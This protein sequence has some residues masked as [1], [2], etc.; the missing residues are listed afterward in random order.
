M[1]QK[2]IEKI[3]QES[4]KVALLA[5]FLI[6]GVLA[7]PLA[8]MLAQAWEE[9]NV[10]VAIVHLPL[11]LGL[12]LD[13][14][15]VLLI[16]A[17]VGF[18]V[19]MTLDPKKR[20]QA[21]LLWIGLV[22]AMFVFRSQGLI[23][24]HIEFVGMIG[25]W[26]GGI[27]TGIL[28]VGNRQL[29]RIQTAEPF[30]FRRAPV[31][32]FYVIGLLVVAALLEVHLSYPNIFEIGS[33]VTLADSPGGS[34][35]FEQT[36]FL[37]NVLVSGIFLA[38]LKRFMEY[39]AQKEFFVLG[40][41]GSGKS[42]F[43]VGSYLAALDRV[44]GDLSNPLTP[45]GTLA[46]MVDQIDRTPE[47]WGIEATAGG[48]LENL[49]FRYV[50]GTVFPKYVTI[51]SLDYA[52]EYLDRLPDALTGLLENEEDST[53]LALADEVQAADMLA[54][55]IDV[56]RV[57]DGDDSLGISSYFPILQAVDDTEVVLIATKADVLADQFEAERGIQ[58]HRYFDDFQE[59]VNAELMESENIRSLVQ[60][61]A[62]SD[63]HP[64]YYQTK[65]D[66]TGEMV[67]MRNER[68]SVMTVG[69]EELLQEMG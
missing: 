66:E 67:P 15:T 37:Q 65:E 25:W 55:V 35:Q 49:R 33:T 30:E 28:L 59:Y 44:D 36:G 41:P 56:E 31:L 17:F 43:L 64:V 42:L 60:E 50:N 40:P 29:T 21:F 8:D 7:A 10:V 9:G 16:G 32:I 2:F 20:W 69:Y 52:G 12:G 26:A 51:S 61:T 5:Y 11:E 53:L 34:V 19:M 1:I 63:I 47:G 68:G 54:L 4:E 27:V 18:L 24:P 6:I 13:Q 58:A 57:I 45:S 48:E 23:F 46:E 3:Q 22:V 14:L 38:T 62:G 39:E